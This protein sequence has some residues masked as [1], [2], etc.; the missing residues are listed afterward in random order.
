[1]QNPCRSCAVNSLQSG[2]GAICTGRLFL[3]GKHS[4]SPCSVSALQT[5]VLGVLLD[6]VIV[7][8]IQ[9]KELEAQRKGE[10]RVGVEWTP[11]LPMLPLV[12]SEHSER[13][14]L[15]TSM[16]LVSNALGIGPNR[17]VNVK[18]LPVTRMLPPWPFIM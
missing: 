2:S 6:H 3:F 17:L 7:H 9:M 5:L 13:L 1:M 18:C 12:N 16:G 15:N 4:H 14:V 11:E 8:A 10:V